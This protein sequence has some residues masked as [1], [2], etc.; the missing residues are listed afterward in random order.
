MCSSGAHTS[1][2]RL[3]DVSHIALI[4]TADVCNLTGVLLCSKSDVITLEQAVA[5][6]LKNLNRF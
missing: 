3:Q 1:V 6:F 2:R 5:K 4:D